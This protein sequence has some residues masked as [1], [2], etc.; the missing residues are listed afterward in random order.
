MQTTEPDTNTRCKNLILIVGS[1]PLP[2]YITTMML[3]PQNVFLI[4]SEATNKVKNSL[5]NSLSAAIQNINIDTS[6]KISSDVRN[7]NDVF[8]HQIINV[9]KN[10]LQVSHLNY[11]GGTKQMASHI[12]KLWYSYFDDP[13]EASKRTSYLDDTKELLVFDNNETLK[14]NVSL[15]FQVLSTLHSI[16]DIK[17]RT[18]PNRIPPVDYLNQDSLHNLIG[19]RFI[20]KPD[21]KPEINRNLKAQMDSFFNTPNYENNKKKKKNRLKQDEI[22]KQYAEIVKKELT[23]FIGCFGDQPQLNFG[24]TNAFSVLNWVTT[25][26]YIHGKWIENW[27]A[28]LVMRSLGVQNANLKRING[29]YHFT[30]DSDMNCIIG[31]GCDSSN[32][33]KG[34]KK[35]KRK[36]EAD[37]LIIRGHRLYYISCTRS[38]HVPTCKGK[39]FEAIVRSRQIGGD[40]ARCALLSTLPPGGDKDWGVEAIKADVID[41]WDPPNHPIVFGTEDLYNWENGQFRSL[42]EWF[43]K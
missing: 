15:D 12:L 26:E 18:Y 13:A 42:N 24:N 19:L 29:A 22:D 33:S 8:E 4:Y 14:I 38:S 43:S 37:I 11:T 10:D 25:G 6:A 41:G 17:P 21:S 20:T 7:I 9:I 3:K 30:D 28:D 31:V 40:L 27:V 1:N 39:L 35:F 5:K 16:N 36:F 32:E 2:N 34:P 23:G